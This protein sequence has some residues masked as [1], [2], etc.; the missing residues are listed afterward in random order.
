MV[1]Y[2]IVGMKKDKKHKVS[3]E[4]QQS[5]MNTLKK[6]MKCDHSQACATNPDDISRSL[7]HLM[8]L[9]SSY[10]F[11]HY[12]TLNQCSTSNVGSVFTVQE[13]STL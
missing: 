1:P 5:L 8:S 11:P 12:Q 3:P 4:E 9:S 13:T 7:R 2:M 10:L 6:Y